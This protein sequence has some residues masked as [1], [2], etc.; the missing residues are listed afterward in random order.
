MENQKETSIVKYILPLQVL[1][2]VY[3]VFM[4]KAILETQWDDV[5]DVCE[6]S[7]LWYYLTT[8]FI[9]QIFNKND[10]LSENENKK[11]NKKSANNGFLF[12]CSIGLF[13]WGAYELFGI[14]C[15]SELKSTLLYKLSLASW[16]LSCVVLG[17]LTIFLS[18]MCCAFCCLKDDQLSTFR[19]RIKQPDMIINQ[20][21]IPTPKPNN[22]NTGN[23]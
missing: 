9:I 20:T 5:S 1:L 7:N 10:D 4:F 12:L 6:K 17:I 22:D 13:I 23:V 16:I 21:A 15:V 11:E 19:I 3:L 18:G 2:I 14:S 8:V